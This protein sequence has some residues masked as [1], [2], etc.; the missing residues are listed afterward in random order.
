MASFNIPLMTIPLY[1]T[2]AIVPHVYCSV[3]ADASKMDNAAPNST[4]NIDAV[5]K[6]LSPGEFK[7]FE[8]SKRCHQNHLENMYETELECCLQSVDY[9]TLAFL[10]LSSSPLCLQACWR[11]KAPELARSA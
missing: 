9:L 5:K 8:R 2:L 6:R 10:G 7:Q 3:M 4:S 1:Y 11:S